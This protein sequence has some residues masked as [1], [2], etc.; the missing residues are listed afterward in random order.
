MPCFP[1]T[2]IMDNGK[3]NQHGRLEF[4][5]VIRYRNPLLCTMT[6]AA[7]YLFYRRNIAG[8]T[9]PCFRQRQL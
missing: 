5:A 3:M 1:M 4:E 2:M 6:H 7:F 8:E 9:P